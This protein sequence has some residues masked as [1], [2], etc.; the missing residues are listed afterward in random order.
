MASRPMQTRA[1]RILLK[2]SDLEAVI[3]L[4][5]SVWD[6]ST[7]HTPPV[8][9]PPD[10]ASDDDD[11][12]LAARQHNHDQV[13]L[14][15]D[16]RKENRHRAWGKALRILSV[17]GDKNR[18]FEAVPKDIDKLGKLVVTLK[19]EFQSA[20]LDVS[21]FD[22]ENPTREI[23][24]VSELVDDTLAELIESGSQAEL[25]FESTDSSTERDGRRA[26]LDL[27]IGCMPPGMRQSH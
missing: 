20:G 8:A 1:K 14:V 2:E 25:F 10:P 12:V 11:P 4:Q 27:I 17:L 21:S 15:K 16:V 22:F 3:R 6:S 7:P 18:R 13:K 26:L 23:E 19:T 5:D 24:V 9:P